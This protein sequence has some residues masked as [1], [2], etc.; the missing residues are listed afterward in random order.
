MDDGRCGGGKWRMP[1][2]GAPDIPVD[3]AA[4]GSDLPQRVEQ[5]RDVDKEL[6]EQAPT[7]ALPRSNS[8]TASVGF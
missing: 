3:H 1:R 6:L 7:P 5:H 8:R 2:P 4:P